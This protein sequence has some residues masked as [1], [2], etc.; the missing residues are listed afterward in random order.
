MR[1]KSRAAIAE[2]CQLPTLSCRQP[3]CLVDMQRLA[4]E[5]KLHGCKESDVEQLVMIQDS[6]PGSKFSLRFII[7]LVD[8]ALY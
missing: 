7:L 3:L 6:H 4:Y 1:E 2:Q 5:H 8:V